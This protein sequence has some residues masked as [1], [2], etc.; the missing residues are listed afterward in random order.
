MDFSINRSLSTSL[1]GTLTMKNEMQQDCMQRFMFDNHPVRGQWVRL[2]DVYQKIH[3]QRAY[4]PLLAALLNEAMVGVAM[5]FGVAKCRGRLTLQF[6]SDGPLKMISVRCT[7]NLKLRGLIDWEGD[8]DTAE[9]ITQALMQG[10]LSLTYE[11]EDGGEHYQSVVPVE[12]GSLTV[13][14]E[15]YFMQSEQLPTKL[16]IAHDENHVVGLLLQLMPEDSDK[17]AISWEHVTTLAE[18]LE[19]GEMLAH[20]NE[21]LLYRLYHEDTVRIFER[22]PITFG[23]NF[24][25]EK[26]EN[27]IVSLGYDQAVQIVKET[28]QID[29]RCEFCG[30]NSQY[31]AV[32]VENLFKTG[33]GKPLKNASVEH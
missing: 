31:D 7:H 27:A 33:Q 11:P 23:C 8:F 16:Y 19:P 22:L 17:K 26:M 12:G 4:P 10:M 32:D 20:D 3:Q 24:S 25:P 6:L 5:L 13:A 15:H 18:T 14:I 28:G 1:N 2:A 21:A 9:D 29:I 30:R